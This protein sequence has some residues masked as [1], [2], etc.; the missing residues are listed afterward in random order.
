VRRT[1][2][3]GTAVE[4]GLEAQAPHHLAR[5]F[6]GVGIADVQRLAGFFGHDG[7]DEVS[8]DAVAGALRVQ[9]GRHVLALGDQREVVAEDA[10]MALDL[11][12]R[13]V[14]LRDVQRQI[15]Q[16]AVVVV[17]NRQQPLHGQAIVAADE[18]VVGMG[19]G[20]PPAEDGRGNPL[21]G[22]EPQRVDEVA[23]GQPAAASGRPGGGRCRS[24][25]D[26]D[27]GHGRSCEKKEGH[28][29]E[30]G[31][32]SLVGWDEKDGGLPGAA[33]QPL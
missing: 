28:G 1:D 3:P 5:G 30:R 29:P 25:E 26:A 31:R 8:G 20:I 13:Q 27:S 2:F 19:H 23:A 14:R 33:H 15:A 11:A 17:G 7:V 12:V 22:I 9:L 32:M 16:R 18:G 21:P 4:A 6:L 10:G 24:V